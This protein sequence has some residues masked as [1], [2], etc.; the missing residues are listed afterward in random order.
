MRRLGYWVGLALLVFGGAT[1]VAQLMAWLLATDV[2]PVTL[3]SLWAGIHAN[4][5]VG[6]QGLI[7]GSISP[8]LWPPVLW[9]LLLPAW[10]T[11]G[12]LGCLLALLCRPP[13]RSRFD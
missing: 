2:R 7:E 6:F 13:A 12:A 3:G 9:L 4:S 5:L 1:G 11:L 10:L 8:S